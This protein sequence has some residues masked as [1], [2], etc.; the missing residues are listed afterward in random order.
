MPPQIAKSLQPIPQTMPNIP[1]PFPI[2]KDGEQRMCFA[3]DFEGWQKNGWSKDPNAVSDTAQPAT[4]PEPAATP[5]V[6]N[7]S[8][9]NAP[10]EPDAGSADTSKTSSKKSS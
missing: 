7:P 2:Y 8:A 3:V 5:E 6:T 9:Q 1:D 10:P 4:P